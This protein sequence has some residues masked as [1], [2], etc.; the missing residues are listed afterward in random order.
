MLKSVGVLPV[1]AV[2][3]ADGIEYTKCIR[4]AQYEMYTKFAMYTLC[5]EFLD[6]LFF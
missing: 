4:L 1:G 5:D 6:F 2:L 3:R